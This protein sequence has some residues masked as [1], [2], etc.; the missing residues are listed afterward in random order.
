MKN[1]FETLDDKSL[2]DKI[3]DS[4]KL[5]NNFN[6]I[7]VEVAF[8]GGKDSEVIL[9]LCKMAQLNYRAM[10]KNTTIDPPGTIAHCLSKGVEIIKPKMTMFQIIEKKGFPTRRARFCCEILKEYKILDNCVLGIRRSESTSRRKR[11]QEPIICRNYRSKKNHVTQILPILNWTNENVADF[12][13]IR[14]IKCHKLYYNENG[15]F[16]ISKRLGCLGC[17]LKAD[18]GL[19]DFLENPKFLKLWIKAGEKYWSSRSESSNLKKKFNNIYEVF[20]HNIFFNSYQD[21]ANSRDGMFENINYKLF[22]ENFF[23]VKL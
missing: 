17:P 10:Y 18:K 7:V 12:I 6:D 21:F 20:V 5:L 14:N 4:I 9:E 15:A 11:Y 22:I 23:K 13:K 2:D 19:R 8:S 1:L 3:K 16:N